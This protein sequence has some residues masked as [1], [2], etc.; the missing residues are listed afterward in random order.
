MR[1]TTLASRFV[2]FPTS[3][4]GARS[5]V[6]RVNSTTAPSPRVLVQYVPHAFGWKGGNLPFC[7]WLWNR[8]GPSSLGDVPRGRVS[9]RSRRPHGPACARGRQ[10]RDGAPRE[11]GRAPC[12]RLDSRLAPRGRIVGGGRHVHRLAPGAGDRAGGWRRGRD[13]GRAEALRR[14]PADRRL[15]RHLRI[16]PARSVAR[17]LAASCEAGSVLDPLDW[18]PQRGD[19]ERAGLASPGARRAPARDRGVD[20][21]GDLSS[22]PRLRRDASALSGWCQHAADDAR[23]RRSRTTARS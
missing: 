19:G 9:V 8:E 11:P 23:W 18:T 13:R 6:C 12:V 4:G 16:S 15:L 3:S 7:L 17:L 2:G 1:P 5:A 21:R 14:R 22:P 10:P 20:R